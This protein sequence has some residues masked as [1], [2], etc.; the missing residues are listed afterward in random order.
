MLQDLPKKSFK[1]VM[2]REEYSLSNNK[3]QSLA[4]CGKS[5]LLQVLPDLSTCG[6]L[7]LRQHHGRSQQD[8]AS[9]SQR[10]LTFQDCSVQSDLMVAVTDFPEQ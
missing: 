2:T 1:N 5:L 10:R 9:I 8:N 6:R 3:N 4:R 7:A